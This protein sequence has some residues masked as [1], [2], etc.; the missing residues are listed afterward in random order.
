MLLR[1]TAQLLFQ[2]LLSSQCYSSF[3][4]SPWNQVLCSWRAAGRTKSSCLQLPFRCSHKPAL[5]I[6]S[7]S[8][9]CSALLQLTMNTL[10]SS[11]FTIFYWQEDLRGVKNRNTA[12]CSRKGN[13]ALATILVLQAWLRIMFLTNR[14][15]C[16]ISY[17]FWISKRKLLQWSGGLNIIQQVGDRTLLM[18][19]AEERSGLSLEE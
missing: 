8:Q 14:P 11:F 19:T 18:G 13:F 1:W 12:G 6:K 3:L 10:P 5:G 2:H 16:S 15:M 4:F 7:H 17:A 9:G